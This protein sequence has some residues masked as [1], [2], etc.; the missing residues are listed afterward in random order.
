[1]SKDRKD[2]APSDAG[3]DHSTNEEPDPGGKKLGVVRREPG[4]VGRQVGGLFRAKGVTKVR[5]KID[6]LKK[7]N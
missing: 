6:E 7:N 5:T 4:S 3:L 1:M 2:D